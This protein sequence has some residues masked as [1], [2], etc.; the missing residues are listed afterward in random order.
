MSVAEPSGTAY[1]M[2]VPSGD[3]SIP[4][5]GFPGDRIVMRLA[6]SAS[7]TSM[8]VFASPVP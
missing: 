8:V 1:A 5:I 4:K 3:H 7:I 2:R 6:P